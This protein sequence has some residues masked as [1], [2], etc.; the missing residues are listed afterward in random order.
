M[1]I[2]TPES[3]AY[4]FTILSIDRGVNLASVLF[5]ESL[6]FINSAF[7]LACLT[8]FLISKYFLMKFNARSEK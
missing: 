2:G 1:K 6:K 7:W 8:S 3:R 4:L 5:F